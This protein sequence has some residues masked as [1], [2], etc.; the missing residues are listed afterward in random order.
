MSG[1]DKIRPINGDEYRD[2]RG[3]LISFSD[4][5]L[6]PIKRVYII[7]NANTDVI[8]AW[9]GHKKEQK[10]FYVIAGSFKIVLLKPDDWLVP[11]A[12]I[13]YQLFNMLATENKVIHIPGG[14]VNGFKA[15]E[16]NSR[17]M[18]FSDYTLE[19]SIRD[20]FRFD[21]DLWYNWHTS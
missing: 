19:E 12:K 11:S 13:D 5:K 20:D 3:V 7:E 9:Q 18:I 21:K 4:F 17:L 15:E 16:P 2:S 8:R 6:D 1:K 14:F 10:W